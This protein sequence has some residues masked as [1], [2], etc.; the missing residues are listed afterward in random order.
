MRRFFLPIIGGYVMIALAGPARGAVDHGEILLNELSCT[1]C[2]E[3][4]L[5]AAA[6]Q[7]AQGRFLNPAGPVLGAEGLKVTPQWLRAFLMAPNVEQPGTT[8]PDVL[9]ALT[10]SQKAQAVEDLTQFLVSQQGTDDGGFDG[11]KGIVAKGRELYH[12]V[13]CVAC[14]APED[15]PLGRTE[16]P[17]VRAQMAELQESSVALKDLARMTTVPQLAAFLKDPVRFH[18]G[19]RMPSMKLSA[20]EATAIAAYLL[21][22]QGAPAQGEAPGVRYEYYERRVE[23]L[24][25][26]DRIKPLAVGTVGKFD[27]SP[28][29]R[30]DHIALRYRGLLKTPAAGTYQFF[31]QSDDGSELLVD[32]KTVVKNGGIH[33]MQER[34]GSVVLKAGEHQIMVRYFNADG[35]YGLVV[36][37]QGP[38]IAKEEIPASS[39]FHSGMIM[40]PLGNAPFE[41]DA[42][43]AARGRALFAQ[44]NCAACHAGAGM[45]PTKAEPLAELKVGG[46]SDCLSDA[47]ARGLP[48]YALG[49]QDRAAIE[50]TLENR[51]ELARPLDAHAEIER[52]MT[53]L[54][55]YACHQRDGQG[56][57]E[58]LRNAYFTSGTNGMDLG[59]EGRLPPRLTGVGAKL[60]EGWMERVLW[61]GASVRPYMAT[62]MPQFGVRNVGFLPA[63]FLSA[64]GREVVNPE[65]RGELTLAKSGRKLVGI[66]GLGCIACHNFAGH[67]S[68]G[69]PAMDLEW[70]TQRLQTGWF[71]RYLIDPQS[72]RPGTRMPSFWP[73]GKAVNQQVLGGNTDRQIAAL[74]TYLSL[75]DSND[76]PDGLIQ[77]KME[78]TVG[79]E[80]VIYRNF[81][82]GMGPRPIAVGYPEKADLAF[83]A[84]QMR[85]ALI[86]QGAFLDVGVQRTGRGM[87][88]TIAPLGHDVLAGPPGPP[89]AEL[90]TAGA[91]WPTQTGKGAGYFF[92]GYQLDDEMRPAFSYDAGNVH[93][94]DYPMAVPAGE[95]AELKRTLTFESDEPPARLYMRA[96]VGNKI[97]PAPGG[98]YLV[99]G[100]LVLKVP[101]AVVRSSQG[102]MELLAPIRFSGK[103][104]EIEEDYIW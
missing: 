57:P 54:N 89:F 6:G 41:V 43:G 4:A 58:G 46:T 101:G 13:G 47:P 30:K 18:P 56:G 83:D 61:D 28:E 100:R 62:R 93:V 65:L 27:L 10:P 11:Q 78:L 12:T 48:F 69:V 34:S 21:R 81:I 97:A 2:H 84:E 9:H 39:L 63:A 22:E 26:F 104:A 79:T 35:G 8:M 51:A 32:G 50:K 1:A 37:W 95:D 59:D 3:P 96:A 5:P 17:Q 77:P 25:N 91:V 52:T 67:A 60:Q 80:A 31:T 74:W 82:Q 7:G 23:N 45:G 98:G 66:T 36:S 14:H 76:L 75:D 88:K 24:P 102:R 42:A 87:G 85:I 71:H 33:P 15:L 49:A 73:A 19:G 90:A 68:L 16:S 94:T 99:D 53:V 103:K 72:L 20:D 92:R 64:D 55:C 44:F 70:M 38:G 86:W 29:K 40:K